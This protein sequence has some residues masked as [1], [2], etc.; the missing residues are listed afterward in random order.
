M[1]LA[2]SRQHPL[3]LAVLGLCSTLAF[4]GVAAAQDAKPAAPAPA[5]AP[6][7]AAPA[8]APLPDPVAVVNGKALSKASF[9][10]YAGQRA[11][12]LASM[13]VDADSAEARK[14]LID[15][16]VMQELLVQEADRTKLGDDAEVQTQ[17]DQ[18]RRNVLATAAVRKYL[19]EHEPTEAQLKSE[20]DKA[21]ATMKSKEYKARHILVDSEDKAKNLIAELKKGAKFE[22]LA[23]ANSTDASK[24]QGGDLG[25]FTADTMVEPFAKA[26]VA[27][28]KGKLTETPVK[29][30]FGW[31]VIQLDDVRDAT[32]PSFDE[33][34]PQLTQMLQ[35]KLLNDYLDKLKAGAKIELK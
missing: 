18:L 25:W 8:P 34:K 7:A 28:D 4:G 15:E 24:E 22:D 14:E 2:K 10:Y 5:A 16:L 20:Y 26:V 35:G 12:Q 17:L 21:T 30:E 6:A 31:H 1:N 27:L 9:Q 11:R 19:K 3:S 13:G 29:T 33:L 23:K 32:P